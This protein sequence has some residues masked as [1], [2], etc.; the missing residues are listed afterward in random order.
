MILSPSKNSTSH[1]GCLTIMKL[2]VAP[3]VLKIVLKI[4]CYAPT[5]LL[6]AAIDEHHVS[7]RVRMISMGNTS[8]QGGTQGWEWGEG[9]KA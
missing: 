2:G 1:V 6:L 5:V 8:I 4:S 7:V 9:G 3:Q